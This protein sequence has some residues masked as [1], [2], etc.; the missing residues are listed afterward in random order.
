MG[1]WA[2]AATDGR[3][4]RNLESAKVAWTHQSARKRRATLGA[5]V[6]EIYFKRMSAA[7]RAQEG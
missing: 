6:H 2:A 3:R 1:A 7:E 4:A 5:R